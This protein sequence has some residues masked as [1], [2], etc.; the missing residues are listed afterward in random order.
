MR[1]QNIGI[2]VLLL[3]IVVVTTFIQPSFAAPAN[4]RSLV[5]D[6]GLYGLISIGVAA[7]IITGGIDLSIGSLVALSGVLFVQIVNVHFVETDF[8]SE[9][10]ETRA[11][12]VEPFVGPAFRLADPL[13]DISKGDQFTF[14]STSGTSS[15][16]IERVVTIGEES[17]I[18][19][20]DRLQ[21]LRPGVPVRLQRVV[22][23]NPYL[24]CGLVLGIAASI[25]LMH[26]LLVTWGNLQPFVVTLCGLLVYRGLARVLTGDNQV[27]LLGALPEFKARFT[28]AVFELPIPFVARL[29]SPEARWSEISWIEIPFSGV[30]LGVV[31]IAGWIF[32][33]RM[34]WG[35]HLLATGENEK[36]ARYSGVRTKS[37]IVVAYVV[38]SLL[39]G[40]TGILFTLELNSVQPGSSGSFYELYA[41]AAAV[42][43]GCSLRGGRGAILSVIAG[44]A[45]MR[46]L[47]KA[48]IVLGISQ[49]WEMV[50]IGV[51]LLAAVSFDEIALRWTA[52]KRRHSIR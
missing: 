37:L 52:R 38:C 32:L 7:V 10:I 1:I 25:G 17:F 44:A 14:A 13:P 5:R 36:A 46:C 30:I 49:E 16:A 6:T 45:V 9:I 15:V 29:G 19:L 42:L 31:A 24:A 21:L 35:R 33:N 43:G 28:G 12:V 41:I 18:E 4:L 34:V 22:S 39:A 2:F 26:G 20:R 27:G 40:L 51:A 50:I 8:E 23:M 47:Y 11:T 3:L 48:I